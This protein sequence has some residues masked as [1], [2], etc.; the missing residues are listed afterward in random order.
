MFIS[1]LSSQILVAVYKFVLFGFATTFGVFLFFRAARRELVRD[2]DIFD[3]VLVVLVSGLIFGRTFDFL[4]FPNN[5]EFSPFNLIFV[6]TYGG[7]NFVG[8][9]LG[10]LFGL[11]IYLRKKKEKLWYVFDLAASPVTFSIFLIYA[12]GLLFEDQ[13]FSVFSVK[14][15]EN[16]IYSLYFFILFWILKRL[17]KQKK[18]LGFFA[19]LFL[20]GLGFSFVINYLISLDKV[21]LYGKVQYFPLIAVIV[22]AST[23]IIW[24]FLSNRKIVSDTRA[25]FALILLFLFSSK[26]VMT[27]AD[28]A[29]K[30]AK[31]ILLFP[32]F[33]V[34]SFLLASK[35][36][37]REITL[38]FFDF[39]TVFKTK[40]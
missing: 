31:Q 12:F 32:Y 29:G 11:F 21:Y 13:Y 25:L 34:R 18:H 7:F 35:F 3:I 6:T 8:A 22:L 39:L 9:A 17:E 10:A 38:G 16:L 30:F 19:C 15:P 1:A 5:Y 23:V 20:T 37:G 27:S 24:Y 33:L 40:K 36:L 26:R 4:F 14:I 2:N 28:E